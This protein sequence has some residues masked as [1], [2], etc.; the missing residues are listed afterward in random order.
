VS[1]GA[2]ALVL[3]AEAAAPRVPVLLL[4]KQAPRA[5]I[6]SGAGTSRSVA[7]QDGVL[8]VDGRPAGELS[9]PPGAWRVELPGEP[10]RVY[11]GAL[12]V[13][14]EGGVLRLRGELDLEPYVAAVVA[15][16]ARPGT[17]AAALEAL[18][19]AVRSYALAARDR[20]PGGALCDLAHCQLLRA[21]GV[22]Q[23][24]SAAATRAARATAG[25]VLRLPSGEVAA[26]TFHAACGGHTADPREVFG[27]PASGG[28]A[29]PDPGCVGPEWSAELSPD[30]VAA[31]VRR[32][33]AGEARAAAAVPPVLRASDVVLVLGAGGFVVRAEAAD[34][35][36]RVSGDA[37]ARAL[38]AEVG[39]GRIRS[40][41]LALRDEG[42]RVV[43]RGA[44]HGHGVGL[45]QEGAAR[46]AAAGEGRRALLA[47]YFPGARLSRL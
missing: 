45:C 42:G 13:R 3:L 40:A 43:V 5:L 41:R 39:R 28:G 35:A 4:A 37:F 12:V 24:H 32:A 36:W 15:S 19:V 29:A 26:A 30:R 20:H 7:A 2:L 27:S 18:A 25:E 34:G 31:A 21:T 17:P 9:L 38:D 44:G 14:A 11:R 23:D 1:L 6:V 33:L 10:G 47:R 22:P 8:A 16:E 46:W